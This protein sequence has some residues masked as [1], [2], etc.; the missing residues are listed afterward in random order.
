MAIRFLCPEGHRLKAVGAM[1]GRDM[2]CPVC[3]A[4]VRV[5]AAGPRE[6]ELEPAADAG[7]ETSPADG[8][9][10]AETDSIW[11]SDAA[12]P[13]AAVP[14]PLPRSEGSQST[15]STIV[16]DRG[17]RPPWGLAAGLL[18]ATAYSAAP[19]LAHLADDPIAGWT[20]LVLGVAALQTVFVLW[21]LTVR[22]WAA[23]WSVAV[24]FAAASA[25]YGAI[26]AFAF[27]A[28]ADRPLP[29][30]MAPIRHRAGAWSATVLAVY[31]LATYACGSIAGRRR[32]E[33]DAEWNV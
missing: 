3:H 32:A 15:G 17:E 6:G 4:P 33:A 29:W 13:P 31:L 24:V 7:A 14:P 12:P 22:H 8:A 16:P 19:A 2:L 30:G 23:I 9:T 1:A 18:A 25:A 10:T 21:M 26:T 11:V 28:G 27:A 20:R 5:P